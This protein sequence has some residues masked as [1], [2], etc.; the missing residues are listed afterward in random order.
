MTQGGTQMVTKKQWVR[1]AIG[2]AAIASGQFSFVAAKQPQT[3]PSNKA[4]AIVTMADIKPL[5]GSAALKPGVPSVIDALGV[6][7]CRYEW[8]SGGNA[9]T[10]RYDVDISV[11]EAAKMFPG[12]SLPS[13]RQAL[14][15]GAKSTDPNAVAVPGIGDGATFE[16]PR[17]ITTKVTALVKTNVLIMTFE[18]PDA[19]A[20][21]DQVIA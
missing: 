7:A 21:K 14:L 1:I 3:P 4:C 19:R 13:L 11:G 5:A 16:S 18:G 6:V 17:P 20:K 9:A 15:A 2:V 12:L 10:G 8:G